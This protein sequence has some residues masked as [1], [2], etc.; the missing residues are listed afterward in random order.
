MRVEIKRFA[1]P[2]LFSAGIGLFACDPDQKVDPVKLALPTPQPN[3]EPGP[4]T[5][6]TILDTCFPQITKG[7]YLQ[8]DS[9]EIRREGT[10]PT[11]IFNYTQFELNRPAISRIYRIFDEAEDDD[12]IH[13][14]DGHD[15]H[16]SI[17]LNKD[18][19]ARL[20]IFIPEGAPRPQWLSARGP[21]ISTK[22]YYG[23]S[24]LQGGV[25]CSYIEAA[26]GVSELFDSPQKLATLVF[27]IEVCQQSLSVDV[28]TLDSIA[29]SNQRVRQIA[30][31]IVC[32]G[33]GYSIGAAVIDANYVEY[34]QFLRT[35]PVFGNIPF[36][37]NE[38][39]YNKVPRLGTVLQ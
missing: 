29:V 25:A 22:D 20:L 30:R 39:S 38:N 2:I 19:G 32:N 18:I 3:D 35:H 31:E 1:I 37:D 6:K 14:I 16:L 21:L 4:P 23:A 34:R 26:T 8:K 9:T 28:K 15:Y 12:W 11:V 36:I 24:L 5:I 13:K 27:I 33:L 7:G 17:T 10:P